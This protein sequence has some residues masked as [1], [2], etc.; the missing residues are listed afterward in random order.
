[1]I[2]IIIINLSYL[3]WRAGNGD[4]DR[5]LFG[6]QMVVV[7]VVVVVRMMLMMASA[8][9]EPHCARGAGSRHGAEDKPRGAG[10][11]VAG[12]ERGGAGP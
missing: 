10:A 9:A 11:N 2:I 5:Y 1:M 8:R 6:P 3:L 4:R 7:V 12:R